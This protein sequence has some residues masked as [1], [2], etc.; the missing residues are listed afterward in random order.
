M[1]GEFQLLAGV[2][3][4]L[5]AAPGCDGGLSGAI[6]LFTSATPCASCVTVFRQFQAPRL[7]A[8]GV[9]LRAPWGSCRRHRAILPLRYLLSAGN[10]KPPTPG[11]HNAQI[12]YDLGHDIDAGA[13]GGQLIAAV[14][15][16][17]SHAVLCVG[18]ARVACCRV[19]GRIAQVKV[20]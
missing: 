15:R 18:M 5:D 9:A 6:A 12:L 1:C 8:R 4:L 20:R 10:R 11:R 14:I 3:T 2:G 7:R 17:R 19:H 13:A 16:A